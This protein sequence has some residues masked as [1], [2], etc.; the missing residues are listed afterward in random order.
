MARIAGKGS[1][2]PKGEDK[3]K[4]PPSRRN[5]RITHE[6]ARRMR[7]RYLKKY[8]SRPDALAPGAYGRAIFDRILGDPRTVGIRFY[9]GIDDEGRMTILFCG[10]DARGDDILVGTIGDEPFRCPPMCSR[11]NGVLFF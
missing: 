6:K 4:F 2:G 7:Q 8:G 9:P 1:D 5:H 11:P 10:V 3:R